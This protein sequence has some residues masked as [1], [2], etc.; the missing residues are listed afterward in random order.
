MNTGVLLAISV[1]A[2]WI[3]HIAPPRQ[4]ALA[5]VGVVTLL[6]LYG[7]F[8]ANPLTGWALWGGLA[9]GLVSLMLLG[10]F[11]GGGGRRPPR[12][13]APGGGPRVGNPGTGGVPPRGWGP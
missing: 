8:A 3:V 7:I 11:V 10:G 6:L 4:R 9:A 1:L 2:P 13:P 12:R 5:L